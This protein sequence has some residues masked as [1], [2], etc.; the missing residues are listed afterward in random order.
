MSQIPSR[1]KNLTPLLVA[2]TIIAMVAFLFLGRTLSRRQG[3]QCDAAMQDLVGKIAS[4]NPSAARVAIESARLTC[5]SM[6]VADLTA[7]EAEVQKQENEAI[8]MA[9]RPALLAAGYTQEQFTRATILPVCKSKDRMPREM[10]AREVS[11]AP[12]YWACDPEVL[13]QETP[14]TPASCEARKLE[15]ATIQDENGRSV[16]ACKK[17]AEGVAEEQLRKAC[18]VSATAPIHVADPGEVKA[19]C[20][21]AVESLLKAPKTAEFPGMFD[22]DGKPVSADGC[23]TVYSSHVDAENAFGAKLRTKYVCTYDPRTGVATTKLQ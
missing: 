4:G 2:G 7:L 19:R 12:H 20:Q 11:G 6:R 22:V 18:K 9:A 23:I 1:K 13:Y 8:T 5:R 14:Q 3:E 16:G 10:S 21:R 15:F 17:S